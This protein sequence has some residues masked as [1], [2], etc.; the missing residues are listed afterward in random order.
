MRSRAVFGQLIEHHDQASPARRRGM[1]AQPAT[2]SRSAPRSVLRDRQDA[3]EN[4]W[5]TSAIQTN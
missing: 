3:G 1:Q 2:G 4:L 5:S